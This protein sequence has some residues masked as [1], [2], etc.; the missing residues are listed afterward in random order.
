M[1]NTVTQ[2]VMKL[3]ASRGIKIDKLHNY[4]EKNNIE[5]NLA[6]FIK[7]IHNFGVKKKSAFQVEMQTLLRGQIYSHIIFVPIVGKSEVKITRCFFFTE[8]CRL[9]PT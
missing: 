6:I 3:T 8:I 4:H 1:Q 5:G 7:N 2:S 9:P